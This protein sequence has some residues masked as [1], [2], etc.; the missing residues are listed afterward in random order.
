MIVLATFVDGC[1]D[2]SGESGN[3][4]GLPINYAVVHPTAFPS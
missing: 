2:F 1:W 4:Y 3:L